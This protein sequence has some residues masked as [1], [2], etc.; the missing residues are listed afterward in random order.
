MVDRE[1]TISLFAWFYEEKYRFWSPMMT[2][3]IAAFNCKSL[4]T[5]IDLIKEDDPDTSWDGCIVDKSLIVT[6]GVTTSESNELP[7][8]SSQIIKPIV[9]LIIILCVIAYILSQRRKK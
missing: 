2:G 1:N 8:K 6:K 4:G 9:V 5:P 3:S 7:E